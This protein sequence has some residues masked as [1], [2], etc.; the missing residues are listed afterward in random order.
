LNT[1]VVVD[2][3]LEKGVLVHFPAFVILAKIVLKIAL[4][5][6]LL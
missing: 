6:A 1:K 5:S 2:E 3:V 4:V